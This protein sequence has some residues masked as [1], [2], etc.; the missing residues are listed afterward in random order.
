VMKRG[1][2]SLGRITVAPVLL[3][4]PNDGLNGTLQYKA[5]YWGNLPLVSAYYPKMVE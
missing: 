1:S 5:L 2:R 4:L 3:H